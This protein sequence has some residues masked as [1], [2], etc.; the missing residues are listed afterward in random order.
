M[1]SPLTWR[2]AGGWQVVP[3]GQVFGVRPN[4]FQSA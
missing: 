2:V 1:F 3:E 4:S